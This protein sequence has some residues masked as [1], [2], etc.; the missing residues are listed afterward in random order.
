MGEQAQ[1]KGMS[2]GRQAGRPLDA[3][4]HGERRAELAAANR[5]EDLPALLTPQE[6]SRSFR[7][8][9]GKVYEDVRSGSLKAISIHWGRRV[10]IPRDA[11]IELLKGGEL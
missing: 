4:P 6:V 11:L 2:A 10:Y 9:L 1:A 5:L 8:S 3:T 7:V